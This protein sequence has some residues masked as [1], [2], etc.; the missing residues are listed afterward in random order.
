MANILQF[1]KNDHITAV[2]KKGFKGSKENYPPVSIFEKVINKQIT[3]FM[4]PLLSKYKCRFRRGFSAQNCLLAMLEKW[5]SLVDKG[6]AFGVLLTDHSK[7]F[8][9]VYHMN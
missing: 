3:N 1:K 9:I 4:E 5:K 6:K 2:F 8:D 7:A